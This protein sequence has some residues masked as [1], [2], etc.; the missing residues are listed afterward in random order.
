MAGRSWEP[1][2]YMKMAAVGTTCLCMIILISGAMIGLLTG[3]ITADQLGSY[4][5]AG[6]AVGI[7]GLAGIL[8]S[9]LRMA[10]QSPE[11]RK[12]KGTQ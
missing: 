3:R 4:G 8:A 6:T 7:V 9:I 11:R 2:D 5:K 10:F 12:T 1:S